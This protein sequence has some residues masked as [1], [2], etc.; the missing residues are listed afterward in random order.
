MEEERKKTLAKEEK[1]KIERQFRITNEREQLSNRKDNQ[2]R[3]T[4]HERKK[5]TFF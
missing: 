2:L 4:K 5:D 1:K 3:H